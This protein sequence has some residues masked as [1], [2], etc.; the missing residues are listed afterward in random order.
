MASDTAIGGQDCNL[1]GQENGQ[2]VVG[3]EGFSNW[4][5]DNNQSETNQLINIP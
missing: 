1:I 3:G 5:G 4:L 2:D